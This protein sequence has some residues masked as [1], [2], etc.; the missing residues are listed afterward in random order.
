MEKIDKETY[1]QAVSKLVKLAQGDTGGSR[2]A[3][4]VLLSAYN[5]DAWQLNIVDLCVLD[6]SNYKAALDVIRGRVELYIE[7]HTLIANGDRIFEELWHSWQRYHVENR[8]KPLCST[9]SGSGR[10]WVDD[11]TEVVCESCKG[12]GY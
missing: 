7:P 2:V 6:K 10:R 1:G 9:C 8:A 11:S 4:Q 3:A 12:K 5:G